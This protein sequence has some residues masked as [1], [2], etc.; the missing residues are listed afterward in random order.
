MPAAHS[1][2]WTVDMVHALPDDGNRYEVIEGELLVSPSPAWLHQR[3]VGGLYVLL[4]DYARRAGLDVLVAPAAVTWS[5]RTEVQPD[6]LVV[7]LVEG[8]MP[9]RFE[10]VGVLTLAVEV[11]SPS[12][13]R[14]DRFCQA[15]RIS[16]AR[17][18]GIL[19]SRPDG[20]IGGALAGW[21]RGA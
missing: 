4:L 17:G 16:E 21:R 20:T 12:T 9:S 11:L 14:V 2:E 7:P 1:S 19:D 6:V 8:R 5:P 13:M 18:S 10:D 3:A 15:A